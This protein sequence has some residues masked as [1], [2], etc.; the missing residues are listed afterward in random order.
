MAAAER[1]EV[2]APQVGQAA[3]ALL[4]TE[5]GLEAVLWMSLVGDAP[6]AARPTVLVR[7]T[8]RRTGVELRHVHQRPS[9]S[10]LARLEVGLAGGRLLTLVALA[11][12]LADQGISYIF[13]II[14]VFFASF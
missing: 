8:A 5:A 13:E 10:E 9:Q 2:F 6:P 14:F 1:Q 7:Q 4:L 3:R 12:E 11:V